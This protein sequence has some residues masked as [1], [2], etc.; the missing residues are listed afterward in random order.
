MRELLAMPFYALGLALAG[1]AA[2]IG[3]IGY[4]IEGLE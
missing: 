2:A 4:L 1:I 3:Y